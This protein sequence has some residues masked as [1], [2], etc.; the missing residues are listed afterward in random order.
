MRA[1]PSKSLYIK[2]W[3]AHEYAKLPKLPGSWRDSDG[4]PHVEPPDAA[5]DFAMA[6][7]IFARPRPP[8]TAARG[9]TSFQELQASAGTV[10]NLNL[11]EGQNSLRLQRALRQRRQGQLAAVV[12]LGIASAIAAFALNRGS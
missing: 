9:L 3:P 11:P 8:E 7:G 2:D 10:T 4:T 6:R 1:T 5:P 12:G